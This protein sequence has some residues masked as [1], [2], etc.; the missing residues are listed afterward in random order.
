MS[1]DGPACSTAS[2]Q[3]GDEERSE[4]TIFCWLVSE[5]SDLSL[6][7]CPQRVVGHLWLVLLVLGL[8]F[9]PGA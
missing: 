2:R 8:C 7:Q 1:A 6:A 4:F 3:D 9:I 5:V